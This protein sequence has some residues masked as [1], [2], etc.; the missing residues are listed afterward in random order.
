ML[1]LKGVFMGSADIIPG[2]SGGTVALITGIYERLIYAIKTIDLKFIPYFFM[3]FVDRKYF[4]K[5][6]E[7]IYSIDFRFLLPLVL[8]VG[9][10]FLLLSRIIES[11]LKYYPTYS[12]AFFFG[13]ILSSSAVVYKN[14]GKIDTHMI[15][16]SII[17]FL[18]S[19][20]LMGLRYL[21]T[22]HSLIIIFFS[23]MITICAMILPGISGAFVLYFLGQYRYMLNALNTLRLID[24]FMY[25]FGALLGIIGFSH[26]LSLL[27]KKHR[28]VIMS[29]LFG[30]MLGALRK[31]AELIIDQPADML[32][33]IFSSIIGFMIVFLFNIY[34]TLYLKGTSRI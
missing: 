23:G 15:F 24:I 12:Y 16:F 28:L 14:I 29:F 11:L 13:L 32:I 27:I 25:L 22:N 18:F 1:F 21:Q 5:M 26:L 34:R 8:G 2:V 3:G 17:G 4:S 33:T 31:P 30:L 19:F 6:R 7:N 9:T 10:A 20:Y